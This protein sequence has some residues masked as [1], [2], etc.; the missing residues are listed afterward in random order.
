M[1]V[2][3]TPT[4]SVGERTPDPA[5]SCAAAANIA[6]PVSACDPSGIG[7]YSGGDP[8]KIVRLTRMRAAVLATAGHGRQ[9]L[10]PP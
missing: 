6:G 8:L 2:A 10:A 7:T 1:R 5:F 3:A 9:H 4:I